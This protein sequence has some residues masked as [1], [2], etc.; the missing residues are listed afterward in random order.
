M[1]SENR[2]SD[3]EFLSQSRS[4]PIFLCKL[5]LV[6]QA[7][8]VDSAAG[9]LARKVDDIA[10]LIRDSDL[11]WVLVLNRRDQG[12]IEVRCEL[13]LNKDTYLDLTLC[14]LGQVNSRFNKHINRTHPPK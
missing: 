8:V 7:A 4:T 14:P 13:C 3:V 6:F 2:A 10:A 9:T 11:P 5:S 12:S 1:F